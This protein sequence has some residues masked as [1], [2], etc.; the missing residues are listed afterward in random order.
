MGK[1]AKNAADELDGVRRQGYRSIAPAAHH[2]P[3]DRPDLQHTT[4]VLMRTLETPL[5]LQEMHLVRPA[6]YLTQRSAKVEVE[7]RHEEMP[8]DVN[9]EV[10]GDWAQCPR[11]RE[12]TG[13]G[14]VCWA[15]R[16]LDSHCKQHT[17]AISSAQAELHE[18]VNGTTRGLFVRGAS[19]SRLGNYF[20]K[21]CCAS[22]SGR[23]TIP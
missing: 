8:H 18:I 11:T 3:T 13:G 21:R 6:S 9:M 10:D 2:V 23:F 19:R 12:S 15:R 4:S 14:L 1:S 7:F 20:G 5:E 17:V 22:R 16:L